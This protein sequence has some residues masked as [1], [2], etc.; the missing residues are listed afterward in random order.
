MQWTSCLGSTFGHTHLLT[1]TA[2]ILS[3]ALAALLFFSWAR[4]LPLAEFGAIAIAAAVATFAFALI[5]LGQSQSGSFDVARRLGF[6]VGARAAAA[7]YVESSMAFKLLAIVGVAIA[8]QTVAISLPSMLPAFVS[9]GVL[10]LQWLALIAGV[11]LPP[12]LAVGLGNH[13]M[14]VFAAIAPRA[15]SL[16]LTVSLASVNADVSAV[17]LSIAHAAAS[18]LVSALGFF[19]YIIQSDVVRIRRIFQPRL[20]HIALSTRKGLRA[21]TV[22]LASLL[23]SSALLLFVE[24]TEGA[25]VAGAFA[26][27]ERLGRTVTDL[28]V[29]TYQM[30]SARRSRSALGSLRPALAGRS[31]GIG[32]VVAILCVVLCQSFG[33]DACK[34]AFGPNKGVAIFSALQI[35]V[36]IILVVSLSGWVLVFRY[37]ANRRLQDALVPYIA[38]GVAGFM[39]YAALSGN[40]GAAASIAAV[41]SEVVVLLCLTLKSVGFK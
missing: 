19:V 29:L 4:I 31:L 5:D 25:A 20:R 37:I 33:L 32:I 40:V 12:W 10:T 26:M 16:V 38:G 3:Q 17:T 9:S 21:S 39:V 1:L 41:A 28:I 6:S 2:R 35:Q 15:A 13:R 7:A 8:V 24:R 30:D 11:L 23:Y 18:I 36:F 34:W 27:A 22:S 14:F